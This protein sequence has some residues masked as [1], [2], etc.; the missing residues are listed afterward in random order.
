MQGHP[1]HNTSFA[2]TGHILKTLQLATRAKG[3]DLSARLRCPLADSYKV[4][5]TRQG[6]NQCD[7]WKEQ[8]AQSLKGSERRLTN[9]GLLLISGLLL[10]SRK[11]I[12]LA[13]VQAGRLLL[14]HVPQNGQDFPALRG[15]SL[16]VCFKVR[17]TPVLQAAHGSAHCSR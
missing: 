2:I 10:P 6:R 13:W 7:E 15:S 5:T 14:A 3:F 12:Q 8:V 11:E 1:C 17:I 4:L 9:S 16:H